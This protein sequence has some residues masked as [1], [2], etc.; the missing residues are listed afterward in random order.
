MGGVLGSLPATFTTKLA[1]ERGVRPRDL[2]G[3]RDGGVVVE[4]SRG[5]FRRADAPEATFPDLLAVSYR[6]PR[7]IVCCVSAASV[8]GLTD[9]REPSVQIAVSA[10]HN[11]PRI[12]FPPTTVMRFDAATFELGLTEVEAAPGES[13]RVYDPARTVVDVMRLRG[14]FGEPLA[15]GVLA[16]Y[17][18]LRRA[19]PGLLLDYAKELDVL[20]PMRV[21][22]DV[23]S[24]R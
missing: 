17:L 4:L 6:A 7:S 22:L 9:E 13:V 24:A 15:Y 14:R 5:V 11:V 3:W 10:R 18:G 2:Y 19:R 8:H 20:G 12:S 16:R 1:R 23:M 21:A